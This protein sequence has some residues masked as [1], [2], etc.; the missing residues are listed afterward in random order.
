[1]SDQQPGLFD[2]L[3]IPPILLL[4]DP[5]INYIVRVQL[6]KHPTDTSSY[7]L[8]CYF[9]SVTPQARES[10]RYRLR[11][12]AFGQKTPRAVEG[13][14]TLKSELSVWPGDQG[15]IE[16]LLGKLVQNKLVFTVGEGG[17][18]TFEKGSTLDDLARRVP[19]EGSVTPVNANPPFAAGTLGACLEALKEELL[20]EPCP[21]CGTRHP[22]Y[23]IVRGTQQAFPFEVLAYR[24]GLEDAA[25]WLHHPCV[26]TESLLRHPERD[27]L[28]GYVVDLSPLWDERCGSAAGKDQPASDEQGT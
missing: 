10:L 18:L 23:L 8:R 4:Q 7:L 26:Q 12:Y 11:V 16:I 25:A 20:V 6:H 17:K 19:G 15:T 9:D 28:Y 24:A 13:P 22:R 3:A 2:Q 21:R 1:M 14:L 27:L 5:L